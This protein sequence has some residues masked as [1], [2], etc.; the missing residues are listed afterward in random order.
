MHGNATPGVLNIILYILKDCKTSFFTFF[1]ISILYK[2][3]FPFLIFQIGDALFVDLPRVRLD[4]GAKAF[5]Q[6]WG[7]EISPPPTLMEVEEE[8]DEENGDDGETVSLRE[9]VYVPGSSPIG[10]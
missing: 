10:N 9:E 6:R 1:S 2:G 8:G 4:G 5:R 7:Y 3:I